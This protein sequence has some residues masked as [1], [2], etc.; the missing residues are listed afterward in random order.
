MAEAA[1][2]ER[3]S[4]T[5]RDEGFVPV[6]RQE[7]LPPG[8]SR[9]VLAA[10]V[11]IAL[12][13]VGGRLYA[14]DDRCPHARGPLSEG[15]VDPE[16]GVVTC[17]WHGA[18]FALATGGALPGPASGGVTSYPVK[19]EGGVVLVGPARRSGHAPG[20]LA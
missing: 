14:L 6:L 16:S 7:E 19:V 11:P 2:R 13:N 9:R 3:G 5:D 18:R 20:T 10:A 1:T 15:R 17:L 12:F 4:V 8:T